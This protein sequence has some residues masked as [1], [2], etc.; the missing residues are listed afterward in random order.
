MA[1]TYVIHDTFVIERTLPLPI[2]PVFASSPTRQE[3]PGVRRQ[4]RPPPWK[5]RDG[6]TARA[7][8]SAVATMNERTPFPG[9]VSRQ[10]NGDISGHR[11]GPTHRAGHEHDSGRPADLV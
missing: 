3:A 2:E 1:E 10:T 4:A 5:L 6:L 7:G 11:A 8:R 9:A